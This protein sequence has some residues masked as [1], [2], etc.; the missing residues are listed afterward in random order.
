MTSSARGIPDLWA[1][2]G[3]D[4]LPPRLVSAFNACDWTGVRRELST[5]MDGAITDGAYGRE[6]LQLVLQL[7]SGIEPV[8]DRYRAAAMIDH[9]DWDGI[10]AELP[11]QTIEPVEARGLRDILTATIDRDEL[12][13][14]DE[15][16]QRY[17]FEIY[18]SQATRSL[19]RIRRWAS[20]ISGV[21]PQ[22]LWDRDDVAIG[23]HL[24]YR[25]LHDAMWQAIAESQAGRL[26]VAHALAS[27]AQRLGDDGEPFRAAAYD[28]V[29]LTSF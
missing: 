3:T 24:R 16:H 1:L 15:P 22:S 26:E 13:A 17:L 20:R 27:E 6:L 14:Y 9:G 11:N 5:V 25:Q 21:L 8:F 28:V 12:P 7:P 18:E 10:R 2:T 4:E 29:M 19:A 23:R